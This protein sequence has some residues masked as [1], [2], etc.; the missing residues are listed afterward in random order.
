MRAGGSNMRGNRIVCRRKKFLILVTRNNSS[1]WKKKR[2]GPERNLGVPAPWGVAL[3]GQRVEVEDNLLE[4][5]ALSLL[6]VADRHG[7]V[8]IFAGRRHARDK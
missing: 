3:P 5:H 4:R 1:I 7:E 8:D 6:A 2:T